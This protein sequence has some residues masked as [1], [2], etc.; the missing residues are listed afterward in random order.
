MHTAFRTA[1]RSA[2]AATL[3]LAGFAMS[4]GVQAQGLADD[5]L[6]EIIVTATKRQ[7]G[8]DVQDAALAVSA[9][10]ESQIDAMHLRDLSQLGF[11]APSVQLEDIGTTRGTANFTI[12]GIGIN[13]SIPS[14]DPAV[15]VFIDGVYLG[16][17]GGVVLDMFDISSI[18][19]LRGPQGLLFGR[20]V[21]GGAVLIHTTRPTDELGIEAKV[22]AET[23][24]NQ[25][26]SARISG[27]LS[28]ATGGKLAVYHNSDDGWFE[29]LA[30]GEDHGAA[31]T[32]LVHAAYEIAPGG[33]WDAILRYYHGESDGDGPASQN[34]GL[35]SEESFDFAIDEPGF[36]DAKWDM[37]ILETS[38]D[39]GFGDGEIVNILGYRE[40]SNDTLG[41]IDASPLFFF[42][43]LS[44]TDQSQW[45]NELRYSGSFDNVYLTSG[46]FYLK[47]DL[48][49]F[50]QRLIPPA[51]LDIT[52]GGFQDMNSVGI[53]TQADIELTDE[54]TLNLGARYDREEKDAQISA[55]PF[56]ACLLG[57]GCANFDLD[58]SRTWNA[59]TPKIGLQVFPSETT[60]M[61][62]FW[63][64][65]YRS[66]GYNMRH[67]AVLIPNESF[68]Q[69]EL[70]SIE[71]GLKKDFAEGRLRLNAAAYYNTIDD[72]QREV[73]LS[74]PVVGVVQL[75]RNTADATITGFDM[76]F[77]AALTDSLFLQTSLGYVDG[78]YDEVLF[79]I[80]GDGV[81]NQEDENLEIPRLAPWSYG[82]QL[83]YQAEL[84]I[85][86]LTVQ[87]SGYHRD[88]SFYTDNNRGRLR[89]ADMFNVNVSLTFM[90][91]QLTLS[92][93]G[94]NL[95]DE[96]TIGGDT[97]LPPNFPGG[98]AFPVPGLGL[99]GDN[100]TFSPLN[101]GRVWG[102]ELQYRYE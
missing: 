57:V 65:G 24:L 30:T 80:S 84:P 60:Q 72:M 88:D 63:T 16:I 12:R 39:V 61:Y 74:D 5:F 25:Y 87:G 62:A 97:Q 83:T 95:K 42:H 46:I 28:E 33:D 41:D 35:F 9:Y 43:A 26:Y 96:V 50:E 58:D 17:N 71:V 51:G 64:K 37:A 67:T 86:T 70:R 11:V 91:D 90:D 21:T 92:A 32:T 2:A 34:A 18:E 75:I 10:G 69:E 99:V 47:Q 3:A 7:G 19:I 45:S 49:Y 53:F 73:N 22:A 101:K 81:V 23:G 14:I 94:K 79:D 77:S 59:F 36:Y 98:P 48:A 4:T 93:F 13:S 52:G 78:S 102:V 15:G 1:C 66:G 56:N 38:I 76:E 85:G 55:I 29:N 68:D 89:G 44:T 27:P 31:D 40:Y 100:A 54:I 6:E 8:I 20:N 82:A